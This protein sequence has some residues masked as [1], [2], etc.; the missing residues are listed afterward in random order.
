[1][2]T[3]VREGCFALK[4]LRKLSLPIVTG[5]FGIP[6]KLTALALSSAAAAVTVGS[7]RAGRSQRQTAALGAVPR[8]WVRRPQAI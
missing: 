4:L 8:W 7:K 1:V 3:D 5:R 2:L 6:G